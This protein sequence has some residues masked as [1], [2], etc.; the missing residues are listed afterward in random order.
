[1]TQPTAE[2][3]RLSH[4]EDASSVEYEYGPTY[5]IEFERNVGA[6][7]D[8]SNDDDVASDSDAASW[9]TQG[10]GEDEDGNDSSIVAPVVEVPDEVPVPVPVPVLP[11]P[12]PPVI[13]LSFPDEL[14]N[15][16]TTISL[17][18]IP[19]I[20]HDFKDSLVRD[21]VQRFRAYMPDDVAA[22]DAMRLRI[23]LEDPL[24]RAY[25]R[26]F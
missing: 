20:N 15:V 19:S 9:T 1:M 18:S 21:F 14:S 6:D 26:S 24:R 11:V 22:D 25:R 13:D 5:S 23:R 16:S 12:V 8:V 7:Q 3:D 4:E 17:E 10:S 2:F